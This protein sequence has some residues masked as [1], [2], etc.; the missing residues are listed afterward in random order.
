MRQ[1]EVRKL[2]GGYATGTLTDAERDMLFAAALED[3]S[4]FDTLAK[5]EA[6]RE[7]LSDP[8]TRQELLTDLQGPAMDRARPR[9]QVVARRSTARN[10][11]FEAKPP[12]I[13]PA[14]SIAER[15]SRARAPGTLWG[16]FVEALTPRRMAFAGVFAALI[17]AIG[18][19][20]L[21]RQRVMRQG[22]TKT[23]V[24]VAVN[25]PPASVPRPGDARPEQARPAPDQPAVRGPG[26]STTSQTA[27]AQLAEERSRNIP[28]GRGETRPASPPAVAVPASSVSVERDNAQAGAQF[29]DERRAVGP[30]TGGRGSEGVENSASSLEKKAEAPIAA[31]RRES[32]SSVAGAVAVSP[33]PAKDRAQSEQ[34]K[35][36]L[37]GDQIAKNRT[38]AAQTSEQSVEGQID[39]VQVAESRPAPAAP[40][41]T[42]SR[43]NL[44]G[45]LGGGFRQGAPV[46]PPAKSA[47]QGAVGR[48]A[49]DRLRQ[50][51]A[52]V[53]DINGSIVSVSVG[54]NAGLKTG[55]ALQVV[56][57]DRVI[58]VVRLSEARESFAVGPFVPASGV[59]DTPRV[60]DIVRL[61]L[62]PQTT[63]P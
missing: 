55:D 47:M 19:I 7:L 29:A 50:L 34:E 4:L 16:A 59:T 58:G 21:L 15:T 1:E 46:P 44:P 31:P 17:L 28:A 22:D 30:L 18:G 23:G 5:E 45:A 54:T 52:R 48:P 37:A 41:I 13:T 26:V 36:K 39:K 51:N 24:E 2:L 14:V 35:A 56:R 6:L 32:E 60:G 62:A 20:Q 49:A 11:S 8:A 12:E 40:A 63:K 3:Q 27:Q 42:S 53:N 10:V 38:D 43:Q 9:E 57:G 61:A 33:S 25:R